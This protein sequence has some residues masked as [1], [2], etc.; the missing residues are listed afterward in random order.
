MDEKLTKL[1]NSTLSS[2]YSPTDTSTSGSDKEEKEKAKPQITI[3]TTPSSLQLSQASQQEIT[4]LQ[5]Q[6]TT[7]LAS[8]ETS[9]LGERA[10][11]RR[12][13]ELEAKLSRADSERGVEV[14]KLQVALAIEQGKVVAMGEERD[15][16]KMRLEKIKTTLF[17]I[18]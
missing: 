7:T 3:T 10:H 9:R 5:A 6:L 4:D 15:E 12:I 11:E 8:L 1:Q 16:A 17:A 18:T 2:S 14:G 13:L